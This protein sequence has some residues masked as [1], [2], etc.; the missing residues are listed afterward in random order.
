MPPD[1]S[2]VSKKKSGP[3]A[4]D[5]RADVAPL[6]MRDGT[7]S[8]LSQI[9][10]KLGHL[11]FTSDCVVGKDPVKD[12][13]GGYC[14]VYVG[15]I[16]STYLQH[17]TTCTEGGHVKVAIKALR[18]HLDEEKRVAKTLARE[19]DVW[20]KL[21]HPNILPFL[22]FI[23]EKDYPSLISEWV[24]DGTLRKFLKKCPN[25]DIV[26]LSLGIAEG[27][28]YMHDRNFVHSDLKADNILI[29]PSGDPL[30]CDFGISRVLTSSESD[31]VSTTHDGR[32]RGTA[33]W[34]AIELHVPEDGVEPRHSKE[35]DVW[36]FGMT[37]Y[38]MLA[39]EVP[40]AHLKYDLHVLSAVMKGE[41]PRLPDL[42]TD[43][44]LSPFLYSMI[45]ECSVSSGPPDGLDQG[46]ESR[47]ESPTQTIA[48]GG[49]SCLKADE[50]SESM[51]TLR[52]NIAEDTNTKNFIAGAR[53]VDHRDIYASLE[54]LARAL[55]E[56]FE[57]GGDVGHL[58]KAIELRRS[59]LVLHPEGHPDRSWSLNELGSSLW[60]R[61]LQGG[62][63]ED[64]TESI[65]C[66]RSAL[67][68]RPE[69]HPDRSQTLN[70]LGYSLCIRFK[71]GGAIEDITESIECHCSALALR[72]E[73]HPDRSWSLNE[74]GH[75]LSVRF[76][77]G[78]AIEDITESIECHRSALA[79]CPEGHPDRSRSLNEL[80]HSLGVHFEQGGAIEDITESIECH[81]SALALL[82][83]GHPDRSPSLKN[84]GHCLRGRFEQD[85]AI[86]DITE[87]IECYR[88]ALALHPEGHPG[89]SQ[90]LNNLGHSL[91]LRFEQG[92]AIEDITESIKC[93]RSALAL[94]PEGHPDRS[95]TLNHPGNALYS[96]FRHSGSVEDL[97]GSIQVGREALTL[98]QAQQFNGSS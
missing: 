52:A 63:I 29:S 80:G 67:A 89:R 98:S 9:L 79:L 46:H 47:N 51:Q 32:P 85:G 10:S 72:P 87:S 1:R 7:E 84:L 77:Q 19:M 61:F 25:P 15:H 93:Y 64:I 83:E 35:S 53:S 40:Y 16:S 42:R 13:H 50:E 43:M 6:S 21:K 62:A 3:Y 75:S 56:R 41:L 68:L 33:R 86:E 24:E 65:E 37:L 4:R 31:F 36:A 22:G 82:P 71:Q 92:G 5:N 30:I 91:H 28:E 11:K 49:D 18:V 27:L 76:E 44:N 58:S 39:K 2:L 14:D 54:T 96:R 17:R 70:N 38:E 26:R 78:G 57:H 95:L 74:L 88:S 66:Y 59:G 94:R 45:C 34:M 12:A 81:R 69:G 48:A 55:T 8:A 90:T 73:G 97:E 23:I 60:L 20:S